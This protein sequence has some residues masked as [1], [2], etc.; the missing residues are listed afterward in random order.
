MKARSYPSSPIRLAL[1]DVTL[2][3]VTSVNVKA[4]VRALS[5]SLEQVAFADCMLFTDVP[6]QP[7]H[8]GIRV[9]PIDHLD[10]A[11]AYSKFLLS[12]LVRH[13][14]TSHCLVVQWDGHV[15]DARRWRPEFLEYDYIGATWP[16]FDD[17][18]DVGNG[19]FSLRSRRLMEACQASD[20]ISGHPEDVAIC[21]TNRAFLEARGIRFAPRA[22]ADLFA[23]ERAA[24][25][26]TTF[27]FHG[28]FNMPR[29]MDN[30]AFWE[31]YRSLDNRSSLRPDF[32]DLLKSLRGGRRGLARSLRMIA[33][34]A[35]DIARG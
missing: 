33:D 32:L 15:L 35:Y 8:P 27:G 21:R 17:G 7:E 13:V 30:E 10:S 2:C 26:G 19:G 31:A 6:V 23:A 25:V 22:L 34:R 14:E 24:D 4:T 1:P 3:A 20:F 11:A 5:A 29:I 16:Q 9:V 18:H 28:V 12:E